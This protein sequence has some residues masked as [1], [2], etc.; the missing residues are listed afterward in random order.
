MTTRTKL[1]QKGFIGAIGGLVSLIFG[2]IVGVLA[3]RFVFRLFGAN[4]TNGLV[5][6]VYDV[7]GP[8]VAPFMGIFSRTVDLATG[9]LE[10]ETLLAIVVYGVIGALVSGVI[11]FGGRG[12]RQAV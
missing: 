7:S 6:W 8:L 1:N 2:F 11:S 9:R 4:P 10:Y 12:R 3:F 5:D